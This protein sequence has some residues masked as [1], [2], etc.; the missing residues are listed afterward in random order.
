MTRPD[1]FRE[2]VRRGVRAGSEHVVVHLL[3]PV[4]GLP[5]DAPAD[6]T[7]AVPPRLG[8]I[9]SRAV[10]PAVVRNR[11]RRR[12]RHLC[13]AHVSGLPDGSL[14]V[15]RARESSSGATGALLGAELETCLQRA[16]GRSGSAVTP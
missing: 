9:V 4:P 3:I 16:L 8:F 12:L 7:G 15:V 14:L 5:D 2:A 10:G 1:D 6:A 13:R 11:V